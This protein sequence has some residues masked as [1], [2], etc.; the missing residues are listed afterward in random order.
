MSQGTQKIAPEIS[1]FSFSGSGKVFIPRGKMASGKA[2]QLR[3]NRQKK[4][5]GKLSYECI[6]ETTTVSRENKDAYKSGLNQAFYT[7]L[8]KW[9]EVSP[10]C[11]IYE[12]CGGELTKKN[13]LSVEWTM[14]T[15]QLN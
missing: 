2:S 5:Y 4:V 10:S 11:L 15:R 3:E 7:H 13:M 8:L 6:R 12:S 1:S 9:K 14:E